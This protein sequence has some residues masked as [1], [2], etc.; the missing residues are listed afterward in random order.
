MPWPRFRIEKRPPFGGRFFYATIQLVL[1]LKNQFLV[2]GEAHQDVDHVRN[3]VGK[4][5]G[6]H[7]LRNEFGKG[8]AEGLIKEPNASFQYAKVH[9][10]GADEHQQE[11]NNFGFLVVMALEVPNAVANVA[12]ASAG[13][14]T[15][16]I[17]EL[18]VPIQ[19]LMKDPDHQHGDQ[20]VHDTD[21][22]VLY[23]VKHGRKIIIL[24]HHELD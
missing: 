12:V 4:E 9:A 11:S 22:V 17:G 6:L 3:D 16:E 18:E 2:H 19:H 14:E 13:H 7:K 5:T 21:D 23:E 10:V 15:Q 8:S 1:F 24:L 20:G